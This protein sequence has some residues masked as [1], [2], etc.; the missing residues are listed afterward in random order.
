MIAKVYLGCSGRTV[1][2]KDAAVEPQG[3]GEA[4][5]EKRAAE[6]ALMRVQKEDGVI[7]E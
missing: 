1:C 3:G 6:R 2:S 5:Q 7:G 4:E